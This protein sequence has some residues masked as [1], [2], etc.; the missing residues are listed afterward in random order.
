MEAVGLEDQLLPGSC[1]GM[2]AAGSDGRALWVLPDVPLRSSQ[3]P[4]PASPS[5]AG[6][7]CR[8]AADSWGGAERQD[9]VRR[10]VK[11]EIGISRT[12]SAEEHRERERQDAICK[13]LWRLLS[14][15]AIDRK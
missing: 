14:I 5:G 9:V 15:S 11:A 13:S 1:D 2:M 6:R 3:D 12:E 8:S 4:M 7:F 10:D